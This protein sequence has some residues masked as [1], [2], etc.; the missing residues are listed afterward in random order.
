MDETIFKRSSKGKQSKEGKKEKLSMSWASNSITMRK[1]IKIGR[2]RSNNV[3]ID[4]PLVSRQHAII[5]I[6]DNQYYIRDLESTNSTY[7]DKNPLKP[8]ESKRLQKG[9]VINIGK[10]ELRIE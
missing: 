9:S 2:D 1:N 10:T 3:V 6:I 8:G 7:V 4:D 5:E